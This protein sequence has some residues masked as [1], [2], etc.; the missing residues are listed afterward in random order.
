MTQKQEIWLQV[1]YHSTV[2]WWWPFPVLSYIRI[3]ATNERAVTIFWYNW[4]AECHYE[5][6]RSRIFIG[7]SQLPGLYISQMLFMYYKC[8][9]QWLAIVISLINDLME[10]VQVTCVY[11]IQKSTWSSESHKN[12]HLAITFIHFRQECCFLIY[13][14][15]GADKEMGDSFVC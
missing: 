4:A 13:P 10:N 7:T 9:R 1:K 2:I 12:K 11:L 3:K 14:F 15:F 5:W 8:W 6:F